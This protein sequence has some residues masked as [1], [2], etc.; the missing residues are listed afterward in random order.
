MQAFAFENIN[1]VIYRESIR[2]EIDADAA[3]VLSSNEIL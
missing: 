1:R 2:L 3:A